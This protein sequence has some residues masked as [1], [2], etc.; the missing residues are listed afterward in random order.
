MRIQDL[1]PKVICI[2]LITRKKKVYIF[3]HDGHSSSSGQYLIVYR[4]PLFVTPCKY[5][6]Q[7]NHWANIAKHHAVQIFQQKFTL[8]NAL[9][10]LD[11]PMQDHKYT[12][13]LSET[14]PCIETQNI[15][16]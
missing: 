3:L 4:S 6:P 1:V 7:Y 16:P 10:S 5:L 9:F 2:S 15:E 13:T 8:Q 12:S 11:S 14:T